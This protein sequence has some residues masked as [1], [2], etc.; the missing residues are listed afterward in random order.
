MQKDNFSVRNWFHNQY[1]FS[2]KYATGNEKKWI[3][4]HELRKCT[5]SNSISRKGKDTG[6]D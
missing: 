6:N 5:K 2:Q 3:L 4:K 1:S